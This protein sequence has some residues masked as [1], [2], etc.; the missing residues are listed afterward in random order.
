MSPLASATSASGGGISTLLLLALP[1][2]LLAYLFWSQRRRQRQVASMQAELQAGDEVMTS[3][4]LY[5][6]IVT[7][8]EKIV[9]LE[10][11]PDVTVIWDRRAIVRSPMAA[12]PATDD[13]TE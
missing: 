8:D 11:A 10:I 7:M 6:R 3:T 1:L 4:G 2:L 9:R 12:K 5:G 13:P